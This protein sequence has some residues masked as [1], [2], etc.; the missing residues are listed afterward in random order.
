[1]KNRNFKSSTGRLS[2]VLSGVLKSKRAEGYV[3][4]AVQ[5]DIKGD[6]VMKKVLIFALTLAMML[7][8]CAC[9]NKQ[10]ENNPA[11]STS[12]TASNVAPEKKN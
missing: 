10:N 4:T 5:E 1:M 8:V 9:G 11:D 3:D 2:W 7:S 12:N 6:I